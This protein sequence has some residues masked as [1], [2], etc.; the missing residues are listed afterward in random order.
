MFDRL[1]VWDI[2]A[3]NKWKTCYV[4]AVMWIQSPLN[5]ESG[6]QPEWHKGCLWWTWIKQQPVLKK[7]ILSRRSKAPIHSDA[8]INS[9]HQRG[10]QWNNSNQLFCT[11]KRLKTPVS[12]KLT[13]S[14]ASLLSIKQSHS[15]LW[16]PEGRNVLAKT[17]ALSLPSICTSEL[18]L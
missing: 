7:R 9:F 14:L 11:S 17:P 18:V 12:Q 15:F 10:R 16:P 4:W 8:Q 6:R 2:K 1:K 13:L 5:W 3:L